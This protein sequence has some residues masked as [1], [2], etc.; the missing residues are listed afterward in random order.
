[1]G[2]DNHDR[3]M[4]WIRAGLGTCK[5]FEED[6]DAVV[7]VGAGFAVGD[8]V[9]AVDELEVDDGWSV[10]DVGWLVWRSLPR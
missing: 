8:S 7:Y 3:R 4:R 1:V 9:V 10:R 6:G 2:D 5:G